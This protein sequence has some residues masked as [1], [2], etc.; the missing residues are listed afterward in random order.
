[1]IKSD[2]HS[3]S[4]V[5][6]L[7]RH[8]YTKLSTIQAYHVFLRMWQ[9]SGGVWLLMS[10]YFKWDEDFTT[11]KFQTFLYYILSCITSSILSMS[12]SSIR[13]NADFQ[14]PDQKHAERNATVTKR[15]DKDRVA[16]WQH[17][18]NESKNDWDEFVASKSDDVEVSQIWLNLKDAL[19][20]WKKRL[21]LPVIRKWPS[22]WPKLRVQAN[23]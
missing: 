5:I 9:L 16:V 15:S 3:S 20:A 18:T 2:V 7:M 21:G 8:K 12:S 22:G 17:A 1:M 11:F 13:L 6:I 23:Q 19:N 4:E 14:W 10:L